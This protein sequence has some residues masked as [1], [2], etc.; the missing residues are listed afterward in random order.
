MKKIILSKEEKHEFAKELTAKSFINHSKPMDDN[1]I[2]QNLNDEHLI[3]YVD[4]IADLLI[5]KNSHK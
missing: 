1:F 3:N 5:E 4:F 2:A